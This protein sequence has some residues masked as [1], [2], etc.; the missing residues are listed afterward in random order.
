MRTNY[1]YSLYM[2]QGPLKRRKT[3]L[4]IYKQACELYNNE[5]FDES[6]KLF[7]R[8][9]EGRKIF[10]DGYYD[11]VEKISDIPYGSMKE[12]TKDWLHDNIDNS[13][14]KYYL[15]WHRGFLPGQVNTYAQETILEKQMLRASAEQGNASA[16]YQMWEYEDDY[17]IHE[18]AKQG[19]KDAQWRIG[20][21][22]L[23][24]GDIS[25]AIEYLRK[26]A[27][28]KKK[29]AMTQ[30]IYIYR[31]Y[32]YS[33]E[34]FEWFLDNAK[35]GFPLAQ[36]AVGVIYHKGHHIDKDLDKALMWFRKSYDACGDHYSFMFIDSILVGKGY[37]SYRCLKVEEELFKLKA[38]NIMMKLR[39]L[40]NVLNDE[41]ISFL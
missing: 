34:S 23:D 25:K 30:L 15:A 26:S 41:V 18:S 27:L 31:I 7:I 37:N 2:S 32:D 38:N 24:K 16:Q 9:L 35:K 21:E 13:F 5:E 20:A 14:V 10:D 36:H 39:L 11:G 3:D 4:Y 19:H 28:Q 12:E 22:Y 40:P 29:T 1:Y 33:Q 6:L 17:W 8:F